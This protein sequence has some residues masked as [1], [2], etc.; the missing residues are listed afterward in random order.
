MKLKFDKNG[1]LFNDVILKPADFE[2]IFGYNPQRKKQIA[3]L[4]TIAKTIN[5]FGGKEMYVVGSFITDKKLP[6]DID[7]CF[8]AEG[9]DYI[10]LKEKYPDFF[11]K[12][13]LKKI[14][15]RLN[16]HMFFFASFDTEM[17]D[18]FRLDRN[19]NKRGIVK[20]LL[21]DL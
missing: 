7:V 15:D 20:I 5:L 17:L 8:D 10:I 4:F 18:W 13:G 2:K 9:V 11:N 3:N 14:H 16:L 12:E 21:K 1:N 6:N 19:N